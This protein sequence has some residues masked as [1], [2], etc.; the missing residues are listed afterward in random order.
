MLLAGFVFACTALSYAEL[1]AAFHEGGGTA[2]YSRHAFND[3]VS[4]IASWGLFLDYIVTIAISA[5]TI[6]PYL[7]T[8]LFTLRDSAPT[9]D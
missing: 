5:F 4:F 6:A 9:P 7:S 1:S 2:S 3:L 8:F